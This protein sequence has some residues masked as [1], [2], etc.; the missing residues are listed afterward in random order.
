[1]KNLGV[2]SPLQALCAFGALQA[3]AVMQGATCMLRAALGLVQSSAAIE[4]VTKA[5][6]H[7]LAVV[8]VLLALMAGANDAL[9]FFRLRLKADLCASALHRASRI[10]GTAGLPGECCVP[11]FLGLTCWADLRGTTL[12]REDQNV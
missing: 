8:P 12:L 9:R 3:R 11:L 7:T 6:Q 10:R 1:M 5:H 2:D 4:Q